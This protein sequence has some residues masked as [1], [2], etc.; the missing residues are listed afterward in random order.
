LQGSELIGGCFVCVDP[1]RQ[2]EEVLARFSH[3]ICA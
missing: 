3:T 2:A 1:R